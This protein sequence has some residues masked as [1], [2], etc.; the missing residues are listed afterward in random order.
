M[1]SEQRFFGRLAHRY[2]LDLPDEIQRRTVPVAHQRHAQEYVY[3]VPPFVNIAL[4]YLVSGDLA[5]QQSRRVSGNNRQVV[6]MSHGMIGKAQ[7][8]RL[9]ISDDSTQGSIDFQPAAIGCY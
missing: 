5:R 8:F 9:G 1:F 7:H 6:G 2:I 4:F 3:V